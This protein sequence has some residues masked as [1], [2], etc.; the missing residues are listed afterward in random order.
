MQT[1]SYKTVGEIEF[2]LSRSTYRDKLWRADT[3]LGIF[4]V[5]ERR[6][7]YGG[8]IRDTET[9]YRDSK[10]GKFYLVAGRFDIRD[11]PELT[12]PE[13]ITLIISKANN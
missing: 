4:A 10:G 12:L 3:S 11:H 9:G 5:L 8:E 2:V 1:N 13:A 7:G 6:T